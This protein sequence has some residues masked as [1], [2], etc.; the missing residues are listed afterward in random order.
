MELILSQGY[1][2]EYWENGNISR[3]PSFSG[4]YSL[5]HKNGKL[6]SKGNYGRNPSFVGTDSLT[7]TPLTMGTG[8]VQVAILLLLELILSRVRGRV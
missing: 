6:S 2:E 5:T 4:T 7:F 3:N 8:Q 1:W